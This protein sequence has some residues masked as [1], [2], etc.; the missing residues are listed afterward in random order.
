MGKNSTWSE[1]NKGSIRTVNLVSQTPKR[2]EKVVR[3]SKLRILAGP[4]TENSFKPM[5]RNKSYK[6]FTQNNHRTRGYP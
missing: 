4:P 2:T 6:N 5:T 1:K 3:P